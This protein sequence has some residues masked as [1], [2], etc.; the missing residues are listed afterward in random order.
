MYLGY[1]ITI[2]ITVFNKKIFGIDV[3][4]KILTKKV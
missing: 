1:K 2:K 4:H 3:K